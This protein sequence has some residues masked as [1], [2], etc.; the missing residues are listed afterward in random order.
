M[1]QDKDI[2]SGSAALTKPR[3]GSRTCSQNPPRGGRSR[4]SIHSPSSL[5]RNGVGLGDPDMA[6]LHAAK[7]ADL[8]E[9]SAMPYLRVRAMAC[10][11]LAKA[12]GDFVAAAQDLREAID[13]GRRIRV[14]IEYEGRMLADFADL[15]YRAGDLDA[16]L[17]A[18]EEAIAVARRRTDRVAEC[19]CERLVQGSS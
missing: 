10:A 5:G 16:A 7:V 9:Q 15:L 1:F 13:F 8:A 3:N 14:G 17:E 11:G 2:W 19:A 18:T 12:A 6:H 4:R